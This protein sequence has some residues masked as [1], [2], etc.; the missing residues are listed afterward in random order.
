MYKDP[1][2]FS[3]N[4]QTKAMLQAPGDEDDEEKDDSFNLNIPNANLPNI[5]IIPN[6]PKKTDHITDPDMNDKLDKLMKK[7]RQLN[8]D[9]VDAFLEDDSIVTVKIENDIKRCKTV[10]ESFCNNSG[11]K[12]PF[13]TNEPTAPLMNPVVTNPL[14][15][16]PVETKRIDT[17]AAIKNLFE[18]LL[19]L[20][21]SDPVKLVSNLNFNKNQFVYSNGRISEAQFATMLIQKM[22]VGQHLFE[23]M[24]FSKGRKIINFETFKE[25]IFSDGFHDAENSILLNHVNKPK[26]CY[27]RA[28]LAEEVNT[29]LAIAPLVCFSFPDSIDDANGS[30]IFQK[31]LPEEVGRKLLSAFNIRNALAGV[32]R[33]PKNFHTLWTFCEAYQDCWDGISVKKGTATTTVTNDKSKSSDDVAP[34]RGGKGS[35]WCDRHGPSSNHLTCDCP[36]KKDINPSVTCKICLLVGHTESMCRFSPT[37]EVLKPKDYLSKFVYEPYQAELLRR[38]KLENK[39]DKHLSSYTFNNLAIQDASPLNHNSNLEDTIKMANKLFPQFETNIVEVVH[40][41]NVPPIVIP[42]EIQNV[43]PS[44]EVTSIADTG[45]ALSFCDPDLVE[46]IKSAGGNPI[47]RDVKLN[48]STVAG[49]TST[50][51][52]VDIVLQTGWKRVCYSFFM[53]S[54]LRKITGYEV[55]LGRDLISKLKLNSN[56][57]QPFFPR[58]MR[59][60][61][62]DEDV[63]SFGS[64][65]MDE[66]NLAYAKSCQ[67]EGEPFRTKAKISNDES[68]DLIAKRNAADIEVKEAFRKSQPPKSSFINH[69]SAVFRTTIKPDAKEI[70]VRQHRISEALLPAMAEKVNQFKENGVLVNFVPSAEHPTPKSNC[71]L[72]CIVQKRDSA[73]KP[74]KFRQVYNAITL[75][76]VIDYVLLKSPDLR[77]LLDWLM[78]H[79]YFNQFDGTEY[80]TQ[81]PIDPKCQHLFGVHPP[82]SDEPLQ[83][84]RMPFG[85]APAPGHAQQFSD[86]ACSEIANTRSYIDNFLQGYDSPEECVP[87]ALKFR[88]ICEKYNIRINIDDIILMATKMVGL[89]AVISQGKREV[90]PKRIEKLINWPVPKTKEALHSFLA[91]FVF[92]QQHIRHFSTIVEPMQSLLKKGVKF[93][94]LPAH[95]QAFKLLKFAIT[96]LPPNKKFEKGKFNHLITDS[97]EV[98]AAWILIQTDSEDDNV[99]REDNIV[100]FYSFAFNSAQKSYNITQKEFFAAVHA[101]QYLYEDLQGLPVYIST[102]HKALTWLMKNATEA[103]TRTSRNW[104]H[105]LTQFDLRIRWIP[106]SANVLANDLSR[107]Y[108]ESE[109]WGVPTPP[110]MAQVNVNL[111][112]TKDTEISTDK[113]AYFDPKVEEDLEKAYADPNN[114]PDDFKYATGIYFIEN[115]S[116]PSLDDTDSLDLDVKDASDVGEE[117][118]VAAS[119]DVTLPMPKSADDEDFEIL[120]KIHDLQ[121][122]GPLKMINVLKERGVYMEKAYAKCKTISDSCIACIQNKH[123]MKKIRE[124]R[125]VAN[126]AP[127]FAWHIDIAYFGE[128]SE[129]DDTCALIVTDTMSRMVYAFSLDSKEIYY[130]IQ[131]LILLC[132][133]LGFPDIIRSDNEPIFKSTEFAKFCKLYDICQE[134]TTEYVHNQNRAERPIGCIRPILNSLCQARNITWEEALPIAVSILNSSENASTHWIPHNVMFGRESRLFKNINP[135]N[136]IRKNPE[137][138]TIDWLKHIS[139]HNEILPRIVEV[140]NVRHDS[141]ISKLNKKSKRKIDNTVYSVGQI[142]F[143][144]KDNPSEKSD[145]IFDGPFK[146]AEVT[147]DSRY[148]IKDATNSI[149]PRLFDRIQL[150][151]PAY[152]KSTIAEID[153]DGTSVR[154]LDYL[155]SHRRVSGKLEFLVKWL[156]LD[157]SCDEWVQNSLVERSAII[158][159][160]ATFKGKRLP[161]TKKSDRIFI[162]APIVSSHEIA[163]ESV[164]PILKR[165]AVKRP[166]KLYSPLIPSTRTLRIRPSL[167]NVSKSLNFLNPSISGGSVD[168][169]GCMKPVSFI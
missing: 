142:V 152:Y 87:L 94:W 1:K 77:G 41:L 31:M 69:P 119:S 29:V 79:K 45:S 121:H 32:A 15:S 76:G 83:Y 114:W 20:D 9:L 2:K 91:S 4:F 46:R 72:V 66:D 135:E 24:K 147:P 136:V 56:C 145:V 22:P 60:D 63:C 163:N 23:N 36:W 18:L 131:K 160:F 169:C 82:C 40:P 140:E 7:F 68:P 106:G 30:A 93:E 168:Y 70:Y 59:Q 151:I 113:C 109:W 54:G 28:S 61:G 111:L 97:S 132:S 146:I 73:G 17:D 130:V 8:S 148:R 11:I 13:T 153:S 65:I 89:G 10:I 51:L 95:D 99:I 38:S 37:W 126:I 116:I 157:D 44:L 104:M 67:K 19:P 98:A 5:P 26:R 107:M 125:K 52:S 62:I 122:M 105:L 85:L 42:I 43:S 92:F 164:A 120:Q 123:D 14:V 33:T 25:A 139:I 117:D 53:L 144:R 75:N 12:S 84:A 108:C 57:L 138:A 21:L 149:F 86:I 50:N 6:L 102:D 49:L 156:G 127:N 112:K 78:G 34:K 137:A 74:T 115:I 80:F 90:D 143:I 100:M 35:L 81:F 128:V 118:I 133:I 16:N 103:G 3:S 58:V 101:L 141:R 167:Q 55:L 159:Y 64:H 124:Y 39:S 96:K 71:P 110:A 134:F 88:Q 161:K 155:K 150:K 27:D 166:K 154:Y 165:P 129:S 48:V 158:E 162:P 47:I